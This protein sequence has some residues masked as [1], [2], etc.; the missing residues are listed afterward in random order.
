MLEAGGDDRR[1]WSTRAP[2]RACRRSTA[3]PTRRAAST[4]RSISRRR[5]RTRRRRSSTRWCARCA[6]SR[7]RRPDQIVAAV[8]PEYY[9]D[10]ALYKAALEKNLDSFKHDGSISLG[11]RAATCYRD[12]KTFDP[13]VQSATVDLAKTIEHDVPAEGGA[14]VQVMARRR[15]RRRRPGARARSDHVHVRRARGAKARLRAYTA[16]RDTTLDGRRRRVRVGGRARPAAASRRCSTSR[17]DCSRRRR[18]RARVRRAARR[19]Q[20]HAGYMFQ[21][22]ALMPW[23]SALD[24]VTAGLEFRGMRR[25]ERDARGARMARAR[26]TRRLRATAIRTS[27]PAACASASRWRRC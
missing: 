13:T 21:P 27:S 23:R 22:D 8:P 20:P 24:N 6:S 25:R 14:E 9:T 17:P 26:R 16:V 19:H 12:L 4:R 5:I 3:A 10:K 18:A 7:R 11:G 1:R 15:P 2:P